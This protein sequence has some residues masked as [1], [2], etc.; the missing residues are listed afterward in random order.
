MKTKRFFFLILLF[1]IILAGCHKEENLSK[2]D[3]G[4][5]L[6]AGTGMLKIAIVSDIHYMAPELLIQDGPAFQEYLFQDPKLLAESPVIFQRLIQ[7]LNADKPDLLIIS[8]DLTK[9]GELISHQQVINLLKTKLD[10]K[11]KVLV[12]PGNHDIA[13]PDAM[14][15]NGSVITPAQTITQENF[16]EL[17]EDFGYKDAL[18][19]DEHTLSY[20]AEPFKNFRVIFIDATIRPNPE[21]PNEPPLEG[22]ITQETLNWIDAQIADAH[23]KHMQIIAVMHHNLIEHWENQSLIYPGYVINNSAEAAANLYQAG[24]R[25]IFTGHDHSND[26]TKYSGGE[27]YDVETGSMVSN[28][29]PYRLIRYYNND[30]ME[31]T[32]KY[33]CGIQ[34]YGFPVEV[35]ARNY[36][37]EHMVALFDYMLTNPP[38][39][40]PE[41]LAAQISPL[42]ASAFVEYYAGDEVMTPD[43]ETQLYYYYQLL[44]TQGYSMAA[45]VFY[46]TY[47]AWNTDLPPQ[48][49][50]LTL[51]LSEK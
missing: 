33:I 18:S 37:Y 6:K 12:M 9:D 3:E 14:Y 17:Y 1:G 13:N 5:T 47:L 11:I 50:T 15:F 51:N 38:Y 19:M 31:I 49:N 35:Y 40:V 32:T 34:L 7:Q 42:E 21:D 25:V 20:V 36:L 23:G 4:V 46:A 8:G 45:D 43:E 16:K 22:A 2:V 28:P 24:I 29:L 10:S 27:L 39:S 41:E 48:D 44:T 26:I 30:R